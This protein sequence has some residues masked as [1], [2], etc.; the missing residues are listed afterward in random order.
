MLLSHIFPLT[1]TPDF[2][3]TEIIQSLLLFYDNIINAYMV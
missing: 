1:N 3:G 2:F